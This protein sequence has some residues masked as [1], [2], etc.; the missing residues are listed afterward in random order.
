MPAP[1][2]TVSGQP[3]WDWTEIEAWAKHT[4]RLREDDI[5]A[6]M[7]ELEGSGWA[8]NLEQIRSDRVAKSCS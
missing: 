8:G 7:L 3:A 4:G 5:F 1:R 6:D 2:W